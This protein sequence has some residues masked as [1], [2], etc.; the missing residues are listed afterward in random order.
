MGDFVKSRIA[1]TL[2][3]LGEETHHSDI[4]TCFLDAFCEAV[5]RLSRGDDIVNDDDLS[6]FQFVVIDDDV[7][8]RA[9]LLA[10]MFLAMLAYDLDEV[11]A[12]DGVA[13]VAQRLG[14]TLEVSCVRVLA[15]CRNADNDGVREVHRVQS[16]CHFV[17]S[18]RCSGLPSVLEKEYLP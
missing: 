1:E 11:E 7:C 8:Q 6:A 17:G 2:F 4:G 14:E 12:V 3:R 10:D 18:P 9:V 15:A 5:S 16:L 13:S